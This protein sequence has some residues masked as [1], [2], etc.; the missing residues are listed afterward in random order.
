MAEPESPATGGD[1]RAPWHF[2]VLVGAATVYLAWRGVE[3]VAWLAG[4]LWVLRSDGGASKLWRRPAGEPAPSP[5]V[6]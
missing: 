1:P 4:R 2:K 5:A 6:T 3:G